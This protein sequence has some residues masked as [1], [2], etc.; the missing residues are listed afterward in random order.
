MEDARSKLLANLFDKKTI[1]V[2]KKLLLKKDV[3]YIRDL[4]RETLVSLA[5]TFRIVQKLVGLGLVTKDVQ[6][7]FTWYKL[8]RDSDIYKEIYALVM[9]ATPDPIDMLKQQLK[10][11][12]A[13][14]FNAFMT[15]DKDKK[16]FIVSDI[17]K[18]ADVDEIANKIHEVAGSKPNYMV[19]TPQFFDQMQTIGLI[20]KEKL[21]VL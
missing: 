16:I 12:F 15:K 5:T 4:S 2:L 11:K 7:K 14:A 18:Q 9:G 20:S 19:I 3:F 10:E 8:Q 13:A 1:E 6:D 21:S 17:V